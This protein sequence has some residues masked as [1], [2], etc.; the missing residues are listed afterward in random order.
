MESFPQPVDD[1]FVEPPQ[2]EEEEEEEE[3]RAPP[4]SSHTPVMVSRGE[5]GSSAPSSARVVCCP[6]SEGTWRTDLAH[7]LLE[8]AHADYGEP[9][10][11]H[12][13]FVLYS[14]KIVR[15]LSRE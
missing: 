9:H 15:R 11:T 7:G 4:P 12:L 3:E 1:Y 13:T 8:L 5:A 6:C 2:A 10:R 14:G